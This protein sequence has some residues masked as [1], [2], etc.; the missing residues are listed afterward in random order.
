MGVIQRGRVREELSQVLSAKSL[1]KKP[2]AKTIH[3]QS[4]DLTV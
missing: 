1:S 4:D 3:E 2:I